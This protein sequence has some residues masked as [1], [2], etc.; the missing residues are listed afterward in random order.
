[1]AKNKEQDFMRGIKSDFRNFLYVVWRALNLPAPSQRQYE[2]A[3]FLQDQSN[4]RRIIEAYRGFGKSWITSAYTIWKLLNNRDEKI[5]VLSASGSRATSFTTFVQR[6]ILEIPYLQHLVPPAHMRWSTRAFDV[7]GTRPAHAPSVKSSGITSQITGSRATEII[8]D[9]VETIN[10]VETEVARAKLYQ[11]LSEMEHILVPEG[12]ITYLGT[13]HHTDS[14]YGKS[15]LLSR[16]YKAYIVPARY[17]K[18]DSLSV[19]NG[20]LSPQI[21]EELDKDPSL[22]WKPTDPER[23]SEETLKIKELGGGKS[24][25]MMQYMLNTLLSDDLKYPLKLSDLIVFDT[26]TIKAPAT[27]RHSSK[28]EDKLDYPGVGI[29]G[30]DSFYKPSRVDSE[31]LEY[32]GIYMAIDPSGRG[33]DQTTYAI[34]GQLYGKLYG[35]DIGGYDGGYNDDTLIDLA[36]K[37]KQY[38][39]NKIIIESNF[40]DGLFT[41]LFKP[42]LL[43]FHRCGLEEVRQ[44]KQKEQ[45]IISTLEPVMNQ[46]RL[47]IDS[48]IIEREY[49]LLHD[50][51]VMHYSLLYQL[52]HLTEEK[53]SIK[54]DDKVDVL[55]IAV[56]SW[57]EALGLDEEKMLQLYKE[58]QFEKQL[59]GF[60]ETTNGYIIDTSKNKSNKHKEDLRYNFLK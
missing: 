23:F 27:I 28:E 39:V 49:K 24:D 21:A 26:D 6:L 38:N 37:A 10:T 18:I 59:E 17:P 44:S 36:R 2:V 15:K 29:N 19:Y 45:R 25:F 8:L 56:Q 22:E 30:R 16:G 11:T 7:N 46:H 42:V 53:D 32:Q 34:V 58:E 60:Y 33:K 48:D 13:P 35:L 55:A 50:P 57:Q 9:D 41:E 31:W 40:G 4:K 1:M 20:F 3:D 54:H 51:N 47:I 52:T 5:M 12:I 14:I 43:K